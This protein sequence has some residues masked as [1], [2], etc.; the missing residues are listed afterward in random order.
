MCVW[1]GG[2]R[3]RQQG[4]GEWK[5]YGM[6]GCNNVLRM[7]AHTRARAHTQTQHTHAQVA[8]GVATAGVVVGLA[9]QYRVS[10]PVLTAVA[11]VRLGQFV[12]LVLARP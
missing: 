11:Q 1:G 5:G 9:R 7:R 6:K 4:S 3:V 8:E 2:G 12:G 10:I